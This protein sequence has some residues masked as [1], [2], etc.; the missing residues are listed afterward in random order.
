M[1]KETNI[2]PF[3]EEGLNAFKQFKFSGINTGNLM[4]IYQ[5]NLELLNA[6]QQITAEAAQSIVELHHQYM[7][8]AFQQWNNQIK[9][10]CSK[11]PLD[12]KTAFHSEA[13]KAAVDQVIEHTRALNSIITKSNEKLNETVQKHF[14]EGLDESINMAKKTKEKR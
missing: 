3:M 12:E 4:S 1:T 5:K 6:T 2:P 13:A 11:S 9:S 14:K 7:K 8:N 10:C